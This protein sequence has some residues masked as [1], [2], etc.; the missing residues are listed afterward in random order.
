MKHAIPP[1]IPITSSMATHAHYD[2]GEQALY[3]KFLSG[4]V[5][6][7]EGVPV[8]KGT[9]VMQAHSFGSSLNRL[10]LGKHEG[11]RVG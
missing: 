11:K 5:H 7:Y 9:T 1:L 8:D 3:V 10:V 6:R 4:A 2:P